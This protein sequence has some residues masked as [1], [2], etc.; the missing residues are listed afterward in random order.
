MMKTVVGEREANTHNSLK[1]TVM[2]LAAAVEA[3]DSYTINHSRNVAAIAAAIAKEMGFDSLKI[4]Q[5]HLAGLLHDI[6]KIGVPDY[7]LQK[8]DKLSPVE[9]EEIKLHPEIGYRI[10]QTGGEIFASIAPIVRYHHERWDGQGYPKGLKGKQIP[11][12]AAILAVADSF[13]A[14][15]SNRSY[16]VAEVEEKALNEI[17]ACSGRQF[18]PKVAR[19]FVESFVEIKSNALSEFS[20]GPTAGVNETFLKIYKTIPEK[21]GLNL[22]VLRPFDYLARYKVILEAIND[23]VLVFSEKWE[24]IDWNK[25][26]NEIYGYSEHELEE[27]PVRK[28]R[29][30]LTA[31]QLDEQLRQVEH[32]GSM[33]FKTE[34]RKKEGEVFP[35]EV[36]VRAFVQAGQ[37]YWLAI[38]RDLSEPKK[39]E[40]D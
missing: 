34:H 27:M 29:S 20:Y 17:I 25:K 36:S 26:A 23:I 5:I 39:W 28:L 16:R 4:E 12:E 15:I 21:R 7:I 13:D 3:K 32:R 31:G 30:P 2:A 19:V 6:G 1:Q 38:I 9:F 24:I 35:V 18:H 10:L 33:I 40:F 11:L 14:I 37:T 8:P 22:R